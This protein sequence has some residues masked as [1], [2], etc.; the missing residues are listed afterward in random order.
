MANHAES[1]TE[2]FGASLTAIQDHYDL[3]N[4]FYAL[5]LDR[6]MV[7]SGALFWKED[8]ALEE[9]Q[10]NK[11]D[12]HIEQ[13]RAHGARRVLD[14]GCGWGACLRRLIDAAGV[15]E[16][17]G[18]TLSA[19]QAA[20]IRAAGDPRIQAHV[21]N[22]QDHEPSVPYDAIISVGAFEH[23][24]RI[25]YDETQK[26]DSYRAFFKYCQEVL[27]RPGGHMSLQ[28]FAYGSTRSRAEAVSEQATRFLA[29]EIFRE[30]DPPHLA[31]IAEAIQSTFEI[32]ALRNDRLDY[33]RTLRI[34]MDRLKKRR[35][36]AVGLVGEEVVERYERYLRYS[37][38][39]FQTGNLDLYRITLRRLDPRWR[40]PTTAKSVAPNQA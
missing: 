8:E 12:Y 10:L 17:V 9:G 35:R 15:E 1:Q 2:R 11:L 39:G 27:L 7:Y 33:A 38:M 19:A 5:W 6:E 4:D 20:Y 13:A 31:N 14:I 30:T 3:S 37:F 28:T 36:E 29:Q 23:F 22:W 16:V 18:L 32:V 40:R 21:E 25:D 24:A 26:V 34:W